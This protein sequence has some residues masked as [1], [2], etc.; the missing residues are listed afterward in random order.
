MLL[1]KGSIDIYAS[2]NIQSNQFVSSALS[3][4]IIPHVL[5]RPLR[6]Q[7]E[8]L[9][10]NIGGC[11]HKILMLT[12]I[13]H[14]VGLSEDIR[15]LTGLGKHSDY[16]LIVFVWVGWA[17]L[18]LGASKEVRKYQISI[19]MKCYYSSKAHRWRS[20]LKYCICDTGCIWGWVIV[21]A[22]DPRAANNGDIC[23]TSNTDIQAPH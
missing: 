14:F 2:W 21:I 20:T 3:L 9:V 7:D 6:V 8:S 13:T 5:N 1:R 11:W 10:T 4:F 19:E 17:G 12:W 23:R 16:V 22:A 18:T 15:G